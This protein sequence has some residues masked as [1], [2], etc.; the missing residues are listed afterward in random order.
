M[1]MPD[2]GADVRRIG[3]SV[4]EVRSD[5]S[6]INQAMERYAD[7]DEAAFAELYD[8]L[9]PKLLGFLRR[10]AGEQ[11]EDLVQQTFF[12]IHLARGTF[13]RG[14]RVKPWAYTIARRL[15]IDRLRRQ[16]R[17]REARQL[18]VDAWASVDGPDEEVFAGELMRE[19]DHAL[20]RIPSEQRKA[21]QLVRGDGLSVR[22]AA[23]VLGTTVA[24][25]KLRTSRAL[26]AIRRSL[27]ASRRHT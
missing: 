27:Q 26:R 5:E 8:A 14:A 17:E 22:D 7:G 21:L 15:L 16:R 9:A 12:Q 18:D 4:G 23:S 1:Q 3:G 10:V 13:T 2:T 20:R 24:A 11:A 19:V 25:V 6:A